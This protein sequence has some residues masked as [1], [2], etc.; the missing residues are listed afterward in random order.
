VLLEPLLLVQLS[1]LLLIHDRDAWVAM[2]SRVVLQHL[3]LLSCAAVESPP[4][5][6]AAALLLEARAALMTQHSTSGPLHT[7]HNVF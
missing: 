3:L 1:H 7:R 4:A 6:S 5:A 2:H